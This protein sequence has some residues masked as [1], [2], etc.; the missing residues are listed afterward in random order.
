MPVPGAKDLAGAELERKRAF[1]TR[2]A[3]IIRCIIR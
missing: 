1:M 2:A 3:I